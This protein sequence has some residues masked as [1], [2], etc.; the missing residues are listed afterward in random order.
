M[1]DA[2]KSQLDAIADQADALIEEVEA[3][4]DEH[5]EFGLMLATRVRVE[6]CAR[7][8]KQLYATLDDKDRMT[9]D[10]TVGRKVVDVQRMAQ[11]LPAP[12]SGRPAEEKAKQE[13]WEARPVAATSSRQP[14]AMGAEVSAPRPGSAPKYRVTGDVESW[15][16]PCGAMTTHTIVAIV[17]DLP[18]QVVCQACNGKHKYRAEPPDK[19]AKGATRASSS[20]KMSAAEVEAQKKMQEKKALLAELDAATNVRPFSPLERYRAGEI[21]EHPEH[22][23]GKIESVLPRSML[24]RFPSG[25]KPVKIA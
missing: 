9:A 2:V 22:G 3:A 19:K 23:R 25:L 7:A 17:G 14:R 11:R 18:A 13:F 12:P 1:D 20:Y 6:E 8:Y 4:L 15:C 5:A 10:R 16:G 24:V 21:I